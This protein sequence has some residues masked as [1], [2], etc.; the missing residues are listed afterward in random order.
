M[1]QHQELEIADGL[2]S[3]SAEAWRAL[4]DAYAEP[5][6]MFV[7]RRMTPCAVEV[8]DVVQETFL[9]AAGSAR[10]FD[11]KQGTLLHWLT[12]IARRHIALCYRKQERQDRVRVAAE[13][14]GVHSQQVISWLENREPEPPAV[15]LSHE[16]ALVIRDTL[17]ELTDEYEELLTWKYLEG[18]KV[19]QIA[20]RLDMSEVAVR[21][22]LARARQA[23]R[24]LFNSRMQ[25]NSLTGQGRDV[26]DV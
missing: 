15:A 26:T 7:A 2:R 1:D 9:A 11:P 24:R 25:D 5:V 10:S 6:W 23:F 22:K 4:Y 20:S 8:P 13:K 17:A 3:G 12:G 19:D 21:S 18:D 14:L 16:M